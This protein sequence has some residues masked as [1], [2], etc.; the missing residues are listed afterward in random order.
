MF[1][2][3]RNRNPILSFVYDDKDARS[4]ACNLLPEDVGRGEEAL[5]DEHRV[6]SVPLLTLERRDHRSRCLTLVL[7]LHPV[8]S[9]NPERYRGYV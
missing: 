1:L 7:L 5:R 6:P 3:Y 9:Y 2:A 8:V 4:D